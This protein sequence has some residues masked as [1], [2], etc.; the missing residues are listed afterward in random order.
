LFF[1]SI[2]LGTI[3]LTIANKKGVLTPLFS[4]LFFFLCLWVSLDPP[5]L[6]ERGALD[7]LYYYYFIFYKKFVLVGVVWRRSFVPY[8]CQ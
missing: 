2:L 6:I 5:S 7:P 4:A 3:K 1:F 8:H